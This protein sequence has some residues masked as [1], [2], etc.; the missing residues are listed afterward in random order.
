MLG[1]FG[2]LEYTSQVWEPYR[3][4]DQQKLGNKILLPNYA[5]LKADSRTYKSVHKS[6]TY[7]WDCIL[8]CT[9]G[10]VY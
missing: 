1:R 5:T 9:G 10:I 4:R 6:P 7:R 3:L 8:N 2:S